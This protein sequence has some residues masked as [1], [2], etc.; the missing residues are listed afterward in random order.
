MATA[1]AKLIG[2]LCGLAAVAFQVSPARADEPQP[3]APDTNPAVF[4]SPGAQPSLILVGAV[5]A[6]G[7]YGAGVGVSYLYPDSPG[8]S[9][10]RIPVAG[11][12]MALAKTGCGD[13]E[14]GC[15]TFTLV[16]RTILTGISAVGQTGG[17]LAMVEGVFLPTRTSREATPEAPRLRRRETSV[18]VTPMVSSRDAIGLGVVG[19]F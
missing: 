11:P 15:G 3:P 6:A 4:P 17:I 2:L 18:S 13:D 1:R 7:W 9:S 14:L 10:L 16:F 5:V 19:Q 12:Y 8:A